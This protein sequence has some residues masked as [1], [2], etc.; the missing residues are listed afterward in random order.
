MKKLDK[1]FAFFN[2]NLEKFK[3]EYINKYIV[4]KSEN[5]LGVYDTFEEAMEQTSKT[6]EVGTF[7]IQKIDENPNTYTIYFNNNVQIFA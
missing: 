6:E 7:L 5:V 1:E 3:K 2:K 4:I